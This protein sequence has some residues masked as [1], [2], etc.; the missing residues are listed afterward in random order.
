MKGFKTIKNCLFQAVYYLTQFFSMQGLLFVTATPKPLLTTAQNVVLMLV[1]QKK[2]MS[3][4]K[5]ATCL[6]W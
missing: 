3:Y 1:N 2:T 6:V 4:K 5:S